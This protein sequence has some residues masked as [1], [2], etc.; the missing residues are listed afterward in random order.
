MAVYHIPTRSGAYVGQSSDNVVPFA[1]ASCLPHPFLDLP[2]GQHTFSNYVPEGAAA[3]AA[4]APAPEEEY[5]YQGVPRVGTLTPPGMQSY[6]AA[7]AERPRHPM[8]PSHRHGASLL[9]YDPSTSQSL[10]LNATALQPHYGALPEEYR[11]YPDFPSACPPGI[12]ARDPVINDQVIQVGDILERRFSPPSTVTDRAVV[13]KLY[14]VYIGDMKV[15]YCLSKDDLLVNTMPWLYPQVQQMCEFA[16][17]EVDWF[18]DWR[19]AHPM[20]PNLDQW[21]RRSGPGIIKER[22]AKMRKTVRMQRLPL[23]RASI[24]IN[25]T[26]DM[27][28]DQ[29]QEAEAAFC[30]SY[31]LWDSRKFAC[32]IRYGT[33]FP[34]PYPYNSAEELQKNLR[35]LANFLEEL[36]SNGCTNVPDADSL[37]EPE[38]GQHQSDAEALHDQQPQS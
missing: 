23:D 32:W 12:V 28:E 6:G 34:Y 3:A 36:R 31:A 19:E 15:M 11:N 18:N 17:V 25:N 35:L 16:R 37:V 20:T 21:T 24:A 13:F 10:R 29:R 33:P 38:V 9:D 7:A 26:E 22:I 14:G 30:E 1:N 2:G 4:A 8:P 27:T 5:R